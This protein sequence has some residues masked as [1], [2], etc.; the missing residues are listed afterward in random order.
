MLNDLLYRLRAFFHGKAMDAEMDE[1]LA[2]HLDREAEKLRLQGIAADEATRRAQIALQGSEQVR[3]QCREARGISFV[4]TVVQDV[5]FGLRM[6]RR[7]PGFTAVVVITLALGIGATTAIFSLVNAVLLRTIP[8]RNPEQL[9]VLQWK[10]H[11]QPSHLSTSS[12]GD[13]VYERNSEDSSGCS[14]SY[15]MFK[16]ISAREDL[17]TGVMAFAGPWNLDLSGNG[18][19]SIAYGDVVSGNYFQ[20]LGVGPALGRT[21]GPEDDTPGAAHVVVLDYGYW[22]RAFGGSVNVLGRTI[23]L[24]NSVFTIV[25]VADRAFTRLTPGKSINLWVPI[26]QADALGTD[27]KDNIKD[28]RWWLTVVGRLKPGISTSEVQSALSLWFVNR[29]TLGDKPFWKK[30]DKVRLLTLPA[31]KGL[32]GIRNQF[33]KP[34][35]LL[36]AAV[37]IVLLIACANVAGLMLARGAARQR[38]MAVRIAVGSGRRRVIRQLLTESLLL[39]FAGA[40]AGILV[41]FFGAR[42]LTAFFSENSYSSLRLNLHPDLPVLLFAIGITVLT[43]IAFGLVPAFR[44]AR[45]NPAVSLKGGSATVASARPG[46]RWFGIGNGLVVLQVALSVVVLSGAGLLMRTLNKLYSI[47]PGFDTQHML[48]FSVEP[49]LAGYNKEKISMLYSELQERLSALPGVLKTTYSSDAL[50]DGGLWTSD[51]RIKEQTGDSAQGKQFETQ[52]LAVGPD[53]ISTMKIPL[54]DGRMLRK[55]D[56]GTTNRGALVNQAFVHKYIGKRNPLGLHFDSGDP[57]EPDWEIVGVVAD[58]KYDSLRRE[59]APTAYI[60]LTEGGATFELR[61]AASPAALMQSVRDVVNK[62]DSSLPV[63]RM[64]TQSESVDRLLFNERLVARLFGLFGALGLLLVCVGLYGLLSF[65]VARRTREIGIRTALGA[66]R[67]DMWILVLRQGV[68]LV[69]AGGVIGLAAAIAVTRLLSSLLYNVRPSDPVTLT[70]VASVLLLVGV[71][72][73]LLPARRATR[74]DPMEALR[75]E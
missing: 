3:Q 35:L 55:S 66:Q 69:F 34:L 10:A 71:V 23:H 43:G 36:M 21:L 58:T 18:P 65:E 42:S 17:F 74:I 49:E 7:S 64:R 38:E 2:Y 68:A 20:T 33:G 61:T 6:L 50:L 56:M 67:R 26:S 72:A 41:A 62:T 70:A 75:C 8:V 31:Q 48:L 14:F 13:C 57:N 12:Y 46:N 53:F 32:A 27:R 40:S 15:P 1:E 28:R 59:E 4:Q 37:G 30:T 19:A 16:E 39:S 45:A 54:V 25:G 5:R 44:G 60:P 73:C 9:V 22:Q 11:N 52:M 29:V 51:V 63:I 24:N 47:D